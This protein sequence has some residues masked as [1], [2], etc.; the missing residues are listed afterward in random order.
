MYGGGNRHLFGSK[1]IPLC[2]L[3]CFLMSRLADEVWSPL[4]TQTYFSGGQGT[5]RKGEDA[6]SDELYLVF[7]CVSG[8][9]S[10]VDW[11]WEKAM[12]GSLYSMAG[13]QGDG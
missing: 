9:F 6:I 11:K 1:V 10:P 3:L 4:K 8:I 12:S 13:S 5:G 7:I 2:F